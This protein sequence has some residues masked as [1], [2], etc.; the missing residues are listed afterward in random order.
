MSAST[1][2][3]KTASIIIG[4]LFKAAPLSTIL[5]VGTELGSDQNDSDIARALRRGVGDTLNQAGKQVVRRNFNIQ[6]TLTIW[7]GQSVRVIVTRD[8]V[9]LPDRE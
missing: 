6:T 4:A 5:A 3:W 9:L 1:L 8:L 2:V 7:L